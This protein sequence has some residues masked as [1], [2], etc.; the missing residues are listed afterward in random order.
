MIEQVMRDYLAAAQQHLT[1][2]VGRVVLS[3]GEEPAWDDCCQGQLYVRL[4]QVQPRNSE[5]GCFATA[6]TYRLAI[7]VVRCAATVNNQG[8]PPSARQVTNDAEE[9]LRDMNQLQQTLLDVGHTSQVEEWQPLGPSGGCHGGEW[10]FTSI[11]V[12]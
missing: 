6:W 10:L 9:M 5:P 7:G 4:R 3:P 8:E 12:V 1:D 2:S 11:L